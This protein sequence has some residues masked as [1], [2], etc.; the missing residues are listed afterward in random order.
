MPAR[1]QLQHYNNPVFVENLVKR[2]LSA[3]S[4]DSKKTDEKVEGRDERKQ[5]KQRG[6]A[7]FVDLNY[8][9]IVLQNDFLDFNF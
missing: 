9:I 5:Q 2:S 1:R 7:H 4:V 3:V 6:Y 8:V